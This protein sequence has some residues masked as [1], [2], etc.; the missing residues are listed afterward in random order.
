M[1]RKVKAWTVIPKVKTWSVTVGVGPNNTRKFEVDAPT[2]RLALLNFRFG[3][4]FVGY[5]YCNVLKI[6]LKKTA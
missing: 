1:K 2:K 3:L 6:G 5:N 4:E